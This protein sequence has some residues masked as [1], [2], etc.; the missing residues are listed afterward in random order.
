VLHGGYG[1]SSHT[2]GM[3]LDSLI[4]AEV[5]LAN[6]SVVTA[7][8]TSN[9]DLFWA[10]RG[11]GSSYGIVTSF[12]FQTH[13]APENNTVFSY[14]FNWNQT[15]I[16]NAFAVLQ[17]YANTTMPLELNMRLMV[18]SYS[19]QLMGVYYGS[20]ADFKAEITPLLTKIG[21][22]SS[23]S[24]TTQGWIDSL[25]TYAYASLTVPLDYYQV[26]LISEFPLNFANTFLA[27]NLCKITV[28]CIV[29]PS[30]KFTI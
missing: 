4:S 22:P 10:L 3:A 1:Y 7:S 15:Q 11:A 12:K 20:Q 26:R 19:I 25:N 18:N 14:N 9:P 17:N 16:R 6:S 13:T 27:R 8:K 28:P 21:T 23:T 29:Y 24:I 5:V 30:N 2:H